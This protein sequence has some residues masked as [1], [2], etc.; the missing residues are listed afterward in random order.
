MSANGTKHERFPI[1]H[2]IMRMYKYAAMALGV[3][4]ALMVA[5]ETF[6]YGLGS[7]LAL[8]LQGFILWVVIY[9]SGEIIELFL[10]IE[11][12]L[13]MQ[14]RLQQRQLQVAMKK[15]RQHELA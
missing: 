8:A 1:L 11:E 6:D 2:L 15:E 14:T 5:F 9:A 7:G 10:S 12:N 13:R 4:I 3:L